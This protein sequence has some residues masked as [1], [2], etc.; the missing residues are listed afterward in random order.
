MDG[1]IQARLD[2]LEGAI[3]VLVTSISTL[4]PSAAAAEALL[5]ADDDLNDE[6]TKCK[7]YIARHIE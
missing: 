6:I 2:A 7:N 5:D 4:N 1:Q 3:D